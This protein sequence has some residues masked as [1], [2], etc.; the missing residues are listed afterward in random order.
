MKEYKGRVLFGG[1][2]HGKAVVSHQGFNTLASF[3]KSGL[4]KSCTDLIASDHNNPDVNGHSLTGIALCLPQTIGSTTGGMLIQSQAKR[5]ITPACWLF[6]KSVD[7]IAASGLILTRVWENIPV[8]VIDN[9]GEDF[10]ASV[11]TDE[12]IEIKEDGTVVLE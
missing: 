9:L 4:K 2:Y 10:L 5:G 6:A 12:M 3:E 11:H 7:P 8:I 1:T